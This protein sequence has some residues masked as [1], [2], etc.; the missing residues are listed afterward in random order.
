MD[1]VPG[2]LGAAFFM[3]ASAWDRR[4]EAGILARFLVWPGPC[5]VMIPA[6]L[7]AKIPLPLN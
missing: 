6:V 1:A 3:A 5:D 7:E 2:A 4:A